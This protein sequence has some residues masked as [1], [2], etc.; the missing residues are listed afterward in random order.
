MLARRIIPCLDVKGGRVV[1]GVRFQELRDTGDPVEC[2]YRYSEQGADEIT[3]LDITAS[4]E[5]RDILLDVVE[6]TAAAVAVPLTVGGGVRERR[7]VHRLLRAGAD[8]VAI[9]SAAVRNPTLISELS[10]AY[11]CQAIVVAVDAKRSDSATDKWEVF[12]RGG[13]EA[14]GIDALEWVQKVDA[15]GAGE[16]L[17]TS[18]DRDGTRDGYDLELVSAVSDVV[19]IPVIA[20][21]G[22]GEPEH[23]FNGLVAGADAALAASIFHDGDYS[24]DEVKSF[25][26]ERGVQV[27]P[28]A[29]AEERST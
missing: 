12:V 23:I 19:E 29:C 13:R 21:G 5:E 27:R 14:T 20:S 2:A 9:N 28:V 18:M 3:F 1:K 16:I 24:I 4:H 25:L 15:L 6:A 26:R 10:G 22:V 8:K 7:D 11:G 17:L